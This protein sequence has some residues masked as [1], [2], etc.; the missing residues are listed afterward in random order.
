MALTA[1][2][3]VSWSFNGSDLQR[4][5]VTK[6]ED[7]CSEIS[8]L[9]I[10]GPVTNRLI[11][12]TLDVSEIKAIIIVCSEDA[13]LKTNSSGSPDN[14]LTLKANEPYIWWVNAPWTN[15]LTVDVTALYL[16]VA[17]TASTDF[18]MNVLYNP[19]V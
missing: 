19:T 3:N 12:C 8:D 7:A 13:T 1:T 6:T 18:L 9:A 11:A 16:T 15:V 2:I 4:E 10:A 14:T 17:A 5:V